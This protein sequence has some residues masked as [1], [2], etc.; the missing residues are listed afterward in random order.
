MLF[1]V[2]VRWG[3]QVVATVGK[4][5]TSAMALCIP[6]QLPAPASPS[7]HAIRRRARS[8]HE[9]QARRASPTSSVNSLMPVEHVATLVLRRRVARRRPRPGQSGESSLSRT[10][11]QR[12]LAC[13]CR[14]RGGAM[15][16]RRATRPRPRLGP[17][18]RAHP[19]VG[20][21]L[22]PEEDCG[23]RR[24]QK[25]EHIGHGTMRSVCG[26]RIHKTGLY[27]SAK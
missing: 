14:G 26:H 3:D 4:T 5:N 15:M 13:A 23:R 27:K 25:E 7:H 17:E 18:R 10:D 19:L 21:S 1:A 2:R 22:M 16:R 6:R 20:A 24:R 9:R 11:F 8:S 12:R